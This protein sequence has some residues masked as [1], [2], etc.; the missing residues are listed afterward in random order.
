MHVLFSDEEESIPCVE[1]NANRIV[2]I[3]KMKTRILRDQVNKED[4][5]Y[6]VVMALGGE[7]R[8]EGG[9]NDRRLAL[10]FGVEKDEKQN[11]VSLSYNCSK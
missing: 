2:Y 10:F 5:K 1:C 6:K 9:I 8:S 7:S 11:V 3:S 4:Y